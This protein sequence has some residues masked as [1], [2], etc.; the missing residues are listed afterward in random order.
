MGAFTLAMAFMG[1]YY[2][3][4]KVNCLDLS[5]NY[6]GTIMAITNGIGATTG[7]IAPALV[8]LLTPNVSQTQI[9]L[10]QDTFTKGFTIQIK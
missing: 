3:G 10:K 4:M 5:P 7:I 1:T 6:S 8:G 2:P 9:K